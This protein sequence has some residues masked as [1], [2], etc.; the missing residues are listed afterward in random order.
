MCRRGNEL[1]RGRAFNYNK[2]PTPFGIEPFPSD[3]AGHTAG[4]RA[5]LP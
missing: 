5:V 1:W 4:P 3:S 2:G